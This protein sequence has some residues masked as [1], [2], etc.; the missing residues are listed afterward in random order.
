MASLRK[1]TV[2][3]P[4]VMRH[5]TAWDPAA[6]T[7]APAP[8][9]GA[10]GQAT[11]ARSTSQPS[12]TVG[13]LTSLAGRSRGPAARGLRGVSRLKRRPSIARQRTLKALRVRGAMARQIHRVWHK[14]A[15][16][17]ARRQAAEGGAELTPPQV[18]DI[19]VSKMPTET[20]G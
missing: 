1:P 8:R 7:F 18:L 19:E 14:L 11:T 4:K 16:Q 2:S 6:V 20:E 9:R 17:L 10:A 12:T 15:R 5:A 3:V 13:I